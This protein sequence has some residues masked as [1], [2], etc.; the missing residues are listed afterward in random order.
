MLSKEI[1]AIYLCAILSMFEYTSPHPMK[2]INFN[3]FLY[4]TLSSRDAKIQKSQ[5]FLELL[6]TKENTVS[7]QGF[8]TFIEVNP[9]KS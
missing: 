4:V 1:E 2:K 6:P 7:C 3:L 8:A 5:L 9:I